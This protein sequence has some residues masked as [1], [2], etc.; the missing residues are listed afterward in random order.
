MLA[1]GHAD[2]N[3]CLQPRLGNESKWRGGLEGWNRDVWL[4]GPLQVPPPPPSTP[5]E[6][7]APSW[8]GD[9]GASTY[10]LSQE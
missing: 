10:F 6:T 1:S 7:S 3:G 5:T 9:T 4:N 2:A 8:M